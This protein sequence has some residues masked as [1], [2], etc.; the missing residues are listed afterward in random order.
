MN[1]VVLGAL[2][3]IFPS[4]LASIIQVIIGVFNPGPQPSGTPIIADVTEDPALQ[5][6]V[7]WKNSRN[8]FSASSWGPGKNSSWSTPSAE[9]DR[10]AFLDGSG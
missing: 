6:N 2:V 9:S 5:I 8:Q 4:R 7:L 10:R 1:S 3:G